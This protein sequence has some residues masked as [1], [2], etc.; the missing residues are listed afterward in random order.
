MSPFLEY[1]NGGI[2]TPFVF[3]SVPDENV[4]DQT[5]SYCKMV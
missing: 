1:E 5:F 4:F 3:Y 2:S